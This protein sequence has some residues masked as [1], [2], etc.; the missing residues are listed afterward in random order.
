LTEALNDVAVISERRMTGAA[1]WIRSMLT[2]F[3]TMKVVSVSINIGYFRVATYSKKR[4][5]KRSRRVY[6]EREE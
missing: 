3:P 5:P 6:R 1:K 4:L 2:W